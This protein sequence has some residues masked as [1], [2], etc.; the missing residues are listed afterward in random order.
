MIGKNWNLI[1]LKSLKVES[2]TNGE[3]KIEQGYIYL[4]TSYELWLMIKTYNVNIHYSTIVKLSFA[5]CV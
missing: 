2:K 5:K 3:T 4:V 1:N